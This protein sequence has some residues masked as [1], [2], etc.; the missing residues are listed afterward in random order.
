MTIAVDRL[1][2]QAICALLPHAGDVCQIEAVGECNEERIVCSTRAHQRVDNPLRREGRL[3]VHA[4]VEMAGQAMALHMALTDEEVGAPPR[5]GMI[6]RLNGITWTTERLDT[7]GG[8]LTLTAECQAMAGPMAR[9]G[10]SLAHDGI[11]LLE[12]TA[13]VWL[14]GND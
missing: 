6:T 4:G 7:L 13:S 10:F 11:V 8:H 9:Y 2:P 5:Q 12:G 3:S 1:T 14:A